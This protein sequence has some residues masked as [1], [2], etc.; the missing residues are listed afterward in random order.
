MNEQNTNDWQYQIQQPRQAFKDFDALLSEVTHSGVL[1]ML[2]REATQSV[3]DEL[4]LEDQGWI[5]SGQASGQVISDADRKA[6]IVTSRLYEA[7]DPLAKQAIRLWTDYTF[8]SG[9]TWATEKERTKKV[10]ESFWNARTNRKILSAQGQRKSSNKLLTDGEVFYALFLGRNGQSTIRHIDPLEITEIITNPEDVEDVRFYKRDWLTQQNQPRTTYYADWTN[11]KG[12]AVKD[13]RGNSIQA[14]DEALIYHVTYNTTGQRGNPLLLP[15]LDWIK[16]YRRFLASRVA[17]MLALARFAWELKTKGGATAVAAVKAVIDGELPA[18]GSTA[19][20]NEGVNLRAIP[21]DTGASNAYQDGRMLKLQVAAAVGI[22]EQY[23]GDISI[24]N[25]ATAKTV[26]LPMMKMFQ[27]YQ[28]VWADVYK[29]INE[30]ILENERVN[31]DEWYVDMDF[32]AI[33]PEDVA[34]VAQSLLAILQ[35]LPELALARDVQ[36]VALMILGINDTDEVLDQLQKEAKSDPTVALTRVL[37][38]FQEVLRK[39]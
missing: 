39:E 29:D 3:E 13:A 37:K 15:A 30:I 28:Q 19:I 18:A 38:R 34:Q 14:T 17:I 21:T 5:R 7:K 32:P 11:A 8:G 9:M 23:F 36:Q 31:P 22:P 35:V 12:K 2:L 1:D 10:L 4:K 25:L 26:E 33:A 20:T 16:Q 6:N 24:G 27:S